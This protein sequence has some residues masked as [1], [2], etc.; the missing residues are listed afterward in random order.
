[1]LYL[2]EVIY[3][4]VLM[5]SL[6]FLDNMKFPISITSEPCITLKG[7]SGFVYINFIPSKYKYK[8]SFL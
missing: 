4:H 8:L 2:L 3:N 1:M 6:F 5:F 7:T